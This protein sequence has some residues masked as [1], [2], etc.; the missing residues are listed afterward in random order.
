V[1]LRKIIRANP[2]RSDIL[3]Q[4]IIDAMAI[5]PEAHEFNQQSQQTVLLRHMNM[6][7][8]QG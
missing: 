1:D 6:T 7:G 2:S 3:D 8:G 4:A 5:K